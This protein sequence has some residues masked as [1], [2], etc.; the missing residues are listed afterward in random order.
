M[1]D[2]VNITLNTSKFRN[3]PQNLVTRILI[4]ESVS[5]NSTSV[6]AP[7][8]AFAFVA[9][10]ARSSSALQWALDHGSVLGRYG[11]FPSAASATAPECDWSNVTS[12]SISRDFSLSRH[13]SLDIDTHVVTIYKHSYINTYT[14]TYMYIQVCL[15]MCICVYFW[16]CLGHETIII[17]A[18]M[19]I[20]TMIRNCFHVHSI[21]ALTHVRLY[22]IMVA[23]N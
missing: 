5:N 7:A 15:Y 11:D 6:R 18:P 1:A 12:A 4:I 23:Y 22:M 14:Y 8:E 21:S 16:M 20:K 2:G 17:K 19:N 10:V 13:R 3:N 9:S